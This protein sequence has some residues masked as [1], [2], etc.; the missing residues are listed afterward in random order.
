MD[1]AFP[2]KAVASGLEGPILNILA[3]TT[4]PLPLTQVV[5]LAQ[6]GSMSGV[7]KALIRLCSQ[8]LV[9]DVPGGYLFN[10]E[11]V[12]A[13]AVL[14][15]GNMRRELID[16]VHSLSQTWNIEVLLLAFFGS[17]ARADGDNESDIDVL[18]VADA[19]EVDEV[20]G[21]LS[22]RIR[23]WTGNDT[24]V[25]TLTLKDLIR[26]KSKNERILQEW[27]SDLLVIRGDKRVIEVGS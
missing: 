6:C 20:A 25:L 23:A 22:E 7:R 13:N 21:E 10:R 15:L 27:Q 14:A 18:L 1:L 19:Q 8:G 26:M 24:H 11:H 16:R 4:L 9:L 5:K 17:F 3:G 12:A 2:A